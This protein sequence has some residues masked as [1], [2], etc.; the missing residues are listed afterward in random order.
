MEDIT[1]EYLRKYRVKKALLK[2][3]KRDLEAIYLSSPAPAE[4]KGGRSSVHT[5]SDP[6][7]LKAMRAVEMRERLEALLPILEEQTY[8]IERFILEIDDELICA[9]IN[10]HFL[11]GMT[12]RQ[13][14]YEIYGTDA[15]SEA[16]RMAVRR[17]LE[18]R[19]NDNE[20]TDTGGRIQGAEGE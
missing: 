1:L 20:E 18:E 5:P 11:K 6:T 16:I 8:H 2:I 12:W 10:L 7:R 9:A 3:W 19:Q 4:V 13:T 14:S 15:N 17:Y